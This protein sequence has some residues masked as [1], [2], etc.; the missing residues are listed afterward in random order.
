MLKIFQTANLVNREKQK[1]LSQNGFVDKI[2]TFED[3]KKRALLLEERVL[4]DNDT[5]IL[6]LREAANFKDFTK[7]R[8]SLDF[9]FFLE[10]SPFIFSFFEETSKE[11]VNLDDLKEADAYAEY[12]D[13]IEILEKLKERYKQILDKRGYADIIFLPQIYKLNLSFLNSFKKAIFYQIDYLNAFEVK[14]LKQ[15]AKIKPFYIKIKIDKYNQAIA[16]H[17]RDIFSLK[18]G[19]SYEIDLSKLQ[20]IK[21]EPIEEKD[22]SVESF[23]AS[24][25]IS[26]IAYIKRKVYEYI[27]SGISPNKI[28]IISNNDEIVKFLNL[29]D[30]EENFKTKTL[31]FEDTPLYRKLKAV[32]DYLLEKNYENKDRLQRL[33]IETENIEKNIA[34]FWEERVDRDFFENI[35]EIFDGNEK[36]ENRILKEEINSFKK[37]FSHLKEYPLNKIFHLFLNRLK[38][39]KIENGKKSGIEIYKI[40]EAKG[41]EFEALIISDFNENYLFSNSFNDM[42]LSSAIRAKTNMLTSKEFQ[43]IQK[44]HIIELLKKAK[45]SSITLV[46]NEQNPLPRFLFEIKNLKKENIHESKLNEILFTSHKRETLPSKEIIEHYDFS[47]IEL[48]PVKFKTFLDCKRKYYLRYIQK[49]EDFKIPSDQM[50]ERK[51]GILLHEGL[52][53]LYKNY[54]SFKNEEDLLEKLRQILYGLTKDEDILKLSIDLWIK[55]LHNF[56]K[57]EI[58]RQKEG[59]EIKFLEEERK[60]VYD[61]FIFYGKVDRIDERDGKFYIIDY[62]S[63]KIPKISKNSLQKDTNF[64][65]QIYYRIFE[66]YFPIEELYYYDIESGTLVKEDFFDEKL[67]LFDEK[68]KLLKEKEINFSKTDDM[69]KCRYCPYAIICNR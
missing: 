14:F 48:S 1:Y 2:I 43:N 41:M 66:K 5:R 35:F 64:Q 21:K 26:Q 51:T 23:F 37:V 62:K 33:E 46:E 42:F 68:L 28:A 31:D 32:Y 67:Q 11:L 65:L 7:L 54:S 63:G 59:F 69:A 22:F 50:D 18:E 34:P 61:N 17:Y 39:I 49:L 38:N 57:K 10:N 53:L 44:H 4:I 40:N 60:N 19:F 30:K 6:L 8:F 24:N 16:K 56:A 9:I 55:K 47:K 52:F 3:F 13:K 29:F 27:N 36:W 25:T 58:Q 45:K 12:A 15:I 20:I